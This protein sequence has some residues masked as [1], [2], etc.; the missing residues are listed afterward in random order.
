MSPE[1][2]PVASLKD[3]RLVYVGPADHETAVGDYAENLTRALRPHVGELVE[4]R[5]LG[6]GSDSAREILGHRRAVAELVAGGTPGRVLVHA[7][8]AAGAVSAFWSI[9]GLR[10]V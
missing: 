8:L 9:A 4:H 10:G 1:A 2:T 3:Y 7:E 6:P 5:T